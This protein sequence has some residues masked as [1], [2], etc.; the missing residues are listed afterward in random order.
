[1]FW[2]KKKRNQ[3]MIDDQAEQLERDYARCKLYEIT[4]NQNSMK[5]VLDKIERILVKKISVDALDLEVINELN[6]DDLRR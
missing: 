2:N 4:E 6:M 3:K 5:S 1:M